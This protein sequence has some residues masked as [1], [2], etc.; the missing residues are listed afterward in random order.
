MTEIYNYVLAFF[1]GVSGY[2]LASAIAWEI[3][4]NESR[5]LMMTGMNVFWVMFMLSFVVMMITFL[6][7]CR[8]DKLNESKSK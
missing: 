6:I 7:K 5:A 1:G 3:P 4:Y 8:K 2:T